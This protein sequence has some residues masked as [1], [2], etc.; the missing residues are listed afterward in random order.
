MKAVVLAALA[1]MAGAAKHVVETATSGTVQAQLSYDYDAQHYTFS[2]VNLTISR[3]DRVLLN[4]PVRPLTSYA[5][6][7]PARYGKS[8]AVRNL[9]PGGEPEVLVDLYSGGAHCCWYTEVYRY[10]ASA[11]T[12]LLK[13][14]VWGNTFYRAHDL[15]RDGLPELLSGDDRFAYEF[16]SFAGS[17]FPVQI[18]RYRS[19]RF[20]DVTRRFPAL[21]RRD[22]RRQWHLALPRLKGSDNVGPLAAW[23]ADQCLLRHCRSAF[24]QLN[25]LRRRHQIGVGWDATPRK[26]LAHLRRFLRST[27]YL[28]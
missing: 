28:R 3:A 8:L 13:T 7:F 23:A 22:A 9:D 11:E 2:N 17:T 5:S 1:L 27:G 4:G 6:I 10:I 15:D 16:T 19:G 12:Y 21:I 26:F 18:W 20:V 24:R 25:A 14:H